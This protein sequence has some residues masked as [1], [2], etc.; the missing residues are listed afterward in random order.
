MSWRRLALWTAAMVATAVK[1]GAQE[2][3]VPSTLH[4]PLLLKVLSFDRQ[5]ETRARHTL[6]VGVV[7]QGGSRES[8]SARDAFLR[9]LPA[10]ESSVSTLSIRVVEIDL[11]RTT[12][13]A[14]LATER[15]TVLYVTPLRA[16]DIA[17]LA[18]TA[19]AA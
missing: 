12:L 13:R 9:A 14:A 19:R 3:P 5:L 11:D 16:V 6:C 2:M 17:A 1:T 10:A 4:V 15:V 18:S 7:F 8:V